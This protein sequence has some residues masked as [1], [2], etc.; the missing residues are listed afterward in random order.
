MKGSITLVVPD[1]MDTRNATVAP[2]RPG[3]ARDDDDVCGCLLEE[4]GSNDDD[5]GTCTSPA[6]QQRP[7]RLCSKV[8]QEEEELIFASE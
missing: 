1:T 2:S 5:S 4:V 6:G 8:G 3:E 7:R